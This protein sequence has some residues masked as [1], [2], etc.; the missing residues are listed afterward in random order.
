MVKANCSRCQKTASSKGF[1]DWHRLLLAGHGK[2]PAFIFAPDRSQDLVQ[3]C[4]GSGRSVASCAART[5]SRPPFP[6][7]TRALEDPPSMSTPASTASFAELGLIEPLERSVRE[8]GYETP[9]PIQ[10]E[11]IPL[12]LEGRDLLGCAR[13]GTGKTAAFALPILQLLAGRRA[14]RAPQTP[15]AF[16]QGEHGDHGRDH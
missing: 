7:P 1:I 2:I 13:T 6:A 4:S 11:A 12:L 3:D 16:G 8:S 9:T 10:T 15:G 14:P 5:K